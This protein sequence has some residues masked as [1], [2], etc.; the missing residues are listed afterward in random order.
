MQFAKKSI[1]IIRTERVSP[2]L[3]PTSLA[4]ADARPPGLAG[5]DGCLAQ[6]AAPAYLLAGAGDDAAG[7][8]KAL[9]NA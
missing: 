1:M 3:R 8:G 5:R 6:V 4:V 2:A 9:P 7:Q